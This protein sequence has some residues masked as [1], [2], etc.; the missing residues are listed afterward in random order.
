MNALIAKDLWTKACVE[1]SNIIE[2]R[3]IENEGEVSSDLCEEDYEPIKDNNQIDKRAL[4]ISLESQTNDDI[5]TKLS[6]SSERTLFIIPVFQVINEAIRTLSN[7]FKSEEIDMNYYHEAATEKAL[8]FMNRGK[9]LLNSIKKG[10]YEHSAIN[11]SVH[12]FAPMILVSEDYFN[13]KKPC[14]LID[15]GVISLK[16][17]LIP[18]EHFKGINLKYVNSASNLYDRYECGFSDF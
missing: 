7:A 9:Q 3:D 18:P 8:E 12:L 13:I 5:P 10:D 6:I 4:I 11:M 17:I 2:T 16:S 14:I 1:F 15:S